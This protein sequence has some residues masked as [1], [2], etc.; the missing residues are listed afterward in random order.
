MYGVQQPRGKS[1][2]PIMVGAGL[3]LLLVS[4]ILLDNQIRSRQPE[5]PQFVQIPQKHTTG[6]E[7]V[8]SADRTTVYVPKEGIDLTGNIVILLRQPNSFSFAGDPDWSRPIVVDIQYHNEEGVHYPGLTFSE[9]VSI[10]FTLTPGQWIDFAERPDEFQVQ[11]YDSQQSPSRWVALPAV[12]DPDRNEL[13]GQTEHLS[14]YALAIKSVQQIPVT[15]ATETPTGDPTATSITIINTP[16]RRP[17]REGEPAANPPVIPTD[18]PVVTEPPATEPPATEP[19]ATEPPATEPPATEPPAEEPTEPP[20][21]E[22]TEP[23]AEEPPPSGGPIVPILPL[24]PLL[25]GIL[26]N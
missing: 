12:M 1:Y 2:I 25:D 9:P 22:P 14:I 10:C 26:N 16:E 5:S 23:P 17:A 18:P 3:A 19:P 24:D 4:F 13:C 21:E 7:I 15:G 6:E 8:V 11:Y 20:A